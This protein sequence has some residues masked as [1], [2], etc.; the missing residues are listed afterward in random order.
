MERREAVTVLME[1]EVRTW[2]L[3]RSSWALE[4][5]ESYRRKISPFEKISLKAIKDEKKW[6]PNPGA[7]T[8]VWVCDERGVAESSHQFSARLSRLRDGGCRRL[9]ILVGGP[10]GL[11]RSLCDHAEHKVLLSPFVLNQEVAL[12]VLF[13][14][15]FRAYTI[16]HNHPYHND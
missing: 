12:T 6:L 15:V 11:S 4:L 2:Q 14:Q 16:M 3:S 10:F 7:G 9:I 5:L 8:R 1:I 13:E